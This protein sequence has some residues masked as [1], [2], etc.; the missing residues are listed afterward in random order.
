MRFRANQ[1]PVCELEHVSERQVSTAAG[2][3]ALTTSE[4]AAFD[5]IF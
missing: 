2:L 4:K 1:M 5:A 3:D